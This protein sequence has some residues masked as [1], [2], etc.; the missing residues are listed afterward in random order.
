MS[1]R[2][3]AGRRVLVVEDEPLIMIDVTQSLESAGAIVSGAFSIGQALSCAA[4]EPFAAAI[5]DFKLAGDTADRL[6]DCLVARAVPFVIHTGYAAD[7]AQRCGAPMLMKP[8]RSEDLV[9]AI[10]AVIRPRPARA[11]QPTAITI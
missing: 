7:Y 2:P 5:V 6:I 8:C 1:G 3:L 9:A 4:T 10:E 11:R